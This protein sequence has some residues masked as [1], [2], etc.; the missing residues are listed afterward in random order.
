MLDVPGHYSFF[1]WKLHSSTP[2]HESGVGFF[3]HQ[4][5]GLLEDLRR[6]GLDVSQLS[7]VDIMAFVKRRTVDV[8]RHLGDL[9]RAHRVERV[10]RW[11]SV[12]A[13]LWE[14]KPSVVYRWLSGDTPAWGSFSILSSAGAQC[15]TVEEVDHAVQNFWVQRV[16]RM[17]AE[18][19]A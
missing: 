6:R 10:A 19:D 1:F 7:K 13:R 12:M 15:A 9:I 14:E 18:V 3:S 16:W 4:L 8:P 17:H 2:S 11:K 5:L